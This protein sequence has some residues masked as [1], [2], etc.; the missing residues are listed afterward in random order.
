MF[1]LILFQTMAP[2]TQSLAC[3][4][5]VEAYLLDASDHMMVV[6][7]LKVVAS[8]TAIPA[9]AAGIVVIFYY[10]CCRSC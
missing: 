8:D 10:P 2:R 1:L 5:N 4:K 3:A 9:E 6:A 7:D